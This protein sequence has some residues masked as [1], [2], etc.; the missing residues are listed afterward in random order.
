MSR[1]PQGHS[2]A[3]IADASFL[4]VLVIY[5]RYI[6]AIVVAPCTGRLAGLKGVQSCQQLS[7]THNLV[8]MSQPRAATK[9]NTTQTQHIWAPEGAGPIRYPLAECLS[10]THSFL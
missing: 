8:R 3:A 2:S 7:L 9:V 5:H 10:H 4:R 1:T 6:R